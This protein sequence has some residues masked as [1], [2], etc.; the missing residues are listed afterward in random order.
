MINIVFEG[1]TDTE[2]IEKISKKLAHI[3]RIS[4]I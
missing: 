1:L 4:H 2:I 3:A